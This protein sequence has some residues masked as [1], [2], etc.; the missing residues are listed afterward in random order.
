M[1]CG[2]FKCLRGT[3][4]GWGLSF[5][6]RGVVLL[7]TEMECVGVLQTCSRLSTVL[8]EM[9]PGLFLTAMDGGGLLR[10]S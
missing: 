4:E 5:I 8:S 7:G 3:V 9:T 2:E 10:G 1:T 6:G